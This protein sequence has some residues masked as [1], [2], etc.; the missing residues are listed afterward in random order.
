MGKPVW[1]TQASQWDLVADVRQIL[2]PADITED[3]MRLWKPSPRGAQQFVAYWVA[4]EFPF[5]FP[6]ETWSDWDPERAPLSMKI[7]QLAVNNSWRHKIRLVRLE[8]A[9]RRNRR[10]VPPEK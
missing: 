6:W 1:V 5:R 10:F 2:A 3:S 4:Q 8:L 9:Q 7:A